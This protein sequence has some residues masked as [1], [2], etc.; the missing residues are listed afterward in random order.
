[1]VDRHLVLRK[2]SELEQYLIQIREFSDISIL[3]YSNNWKIQRIVE[4]TLQMMIE[5][6]LDIA[7]HIIS[8]E[9]Y[10]TPANYADMFRVLHENHIVSKSLLISLEKMA[11]FR[12]YIV[13]HYDKVDPHIAVSIL[14][15]NLEDF[16]KFRISIIAYLKESGANREM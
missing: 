12:N 1:M 13:H 11:K 15:R 10:R 14:N 3:E 7:A 16:E 2:I 6:C 5:T 8:D 4:R 9:R